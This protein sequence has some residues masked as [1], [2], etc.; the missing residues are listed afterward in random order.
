MR[1]F[2]LHNKYQVIYAD[3][4]W[5]YNNAGENIQNQAE[6]HYPTMPLD[7]IKQ[8]PV[9]DISDKESVLFMWTSNPQLP[10]A[11][12]LINAWGF[13][14]KTVFKVW[15]KT[16]KDGSPVCVPG[17]WTR[18]STEL[19]LVAAKGNSLH[20]WKTSNNEPQ[21]FASIRGAH[22]EKPDE[23][24]EIIENFLNVDTRIELFARKTCSNWDAW[25]LDIA[26]YFH[27]NNGIS[28]A[29]YNEQTRTIGTQTFQQESLKKGG[30][31]KH[32]PDC[33]CCICKK[34]RANDK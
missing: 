20:K 27:E 29:E 11:F 12:E 32:K 2:P 14:Y 9:R 28:N 23:I 5:S 25:G 21:E 30:T 4:P 16:N 6:N 15:R 24:R 18:S 22:S 17:W 7:A 3:P 33:A 13:D 1:A 10:R 8:I 26:G 34:K 19:L 31:H